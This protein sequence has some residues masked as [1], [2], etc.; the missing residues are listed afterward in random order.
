M[1]GPLISP[2]KRRRPESALHKPIPTTFALPTTRVCRAMPN[3]S[4]R[5]ESLVVPATQ[6]PIVQSPVG[7]DALTIFG[8][9]HGLKP[10][11]DI[12]SLRR[13]GGFPIPRNPC[14]NDG[15]KIVP[16][17]SHFSEQDNSEVGWA[18]FASNKDDA[19]LVNGTVLARIAWLPSL[20]KCGS[21][22]LV[23]YFQ[24]ARKK[25]S[26]LARDTIEHP[27][28]WSDDDIQRLFFKFAVVRDPLDHFLA[29][30]HQL[31]VFYRMGWL[32][33]LQSRWGVEFWNRTCVSTTFGNPDKLTKCEGAPGG[34]PIEVIETVLDDIERVGFFDAHIFPMTYPIA[35]SRSVDGVGSPNFYIFDLDDMDGLMN[36]LNVILYNQS[37]WQHRYTRPR[38]PKPMHRDSTEITPW[39]I[40]GPELLARAET[41]CKARD[42]VQR[43]CRL[44][45][46]DYKCL[47]FTIPRVCRDEP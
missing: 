47:P 9:L 14:E 17:E 38:G 39:V 3:T 1:G 15:T 41:E 8:N 16:I 44:Y 2:S 33:K 22:M 37:Q 32:A 24:H 34:G 7:L 31:Y 43:F 36:V 5:I 35:I 28:R 13:W 45:A 27:L 42:V 23:K 46:E 40:R 25:S 12:G 21:T 18:S 10:R 26:K 29:G 30:V 20:R 19:V 11:C 6:M 4:K